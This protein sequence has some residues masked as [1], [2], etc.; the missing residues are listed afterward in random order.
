MPF[1]SFSNLNWEFGAKK[2]AWR[3]STITEALYIAKRVELIEKYEF[4]K[5]ALNKNA[6]IF[7][8]YIA[9]LEA[10]QSAMSLHLL[11]TLFLVAL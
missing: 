10:P 4:A 5:V 6:N 8:V 2:L 9:A 7:V 3:S 11:C 1:L